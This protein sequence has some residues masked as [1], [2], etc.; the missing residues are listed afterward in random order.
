MIDG[1]VYYQC[2]ANE[3]R[4][5]EKKMETNQV[6]FMFSAQTMA[7]LMDAVLADDTDNCLMFLEFINGK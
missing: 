3:P 4:T 2:Q 6:R 5:Q 1:G 7:D